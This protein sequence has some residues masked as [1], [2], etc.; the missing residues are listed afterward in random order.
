MDPVQSDTG[1][2][3][4]AAS[5]DDI[6]RFRASTDMI[7]RHRSIVDQD[8]IDSKHYSGAFLWGHDSTG[9]MFGSAPKIENQLGKVIKMSKTRFRRED[10][11]M[12]KATDIDV[13][14]SKVNPFGVLAQGMVREGILGNVSI[15]FIPKHAEKREIEGEE[16][17]VYDKIELLEISLV[18]VPSNPEAQQLVRAM[19]LELENIP[20]LADL[21]VQ[22]RDSDDGSW[23][24]SEQQGW[25]F[26]MPPSAQ[27][28]E[29]LVDQALQIED[30]TIKDPP[31]DNHGADT[32]SNVV[33][34][35]VRDWVKTQRSA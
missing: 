5:N 11:K 30:K 23:F 10:R 19:G 35:A 8:G 31:P 22:R 33:S 21:G 16:I 27:D 18:P 15:S 7:D 1:G 14:F 26:R 28:L 20:H 12:G 9:G 4:R 34:R 29:G 24:Y 2:F 3:L 6:L 13:R 25:R 32:G 17:R